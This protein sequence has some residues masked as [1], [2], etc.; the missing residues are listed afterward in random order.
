MAS[1]RRASWIAACATAVVL[2]TSGC[3][4]P[5]SVVT[6][7]EPASPPPPA[8]AAAPPRSS[9]TAPRPT[10]RPPTTAAST[11]LPLPTGPDPVHADPNRP[12]QAYDQILA[13]ILNDIQ[14]YWGTTFPHLYNKPYQPLQGGIFAVFRGAQ[15]VPGCGTRQTTYRLIQGNAFYCEQGDF[16]AFDDQTLFP[17]IYA[18]FGPYTIGMVLAHEWGHAIQ[19][20]AGVTNEPTIVLEQQADCFAGS[21]VGHLARDES[22]YL[23]V[24]ESDLDAAFAG[25]LTFSDQPGTTADQEQAHGSGFD[26][27]GAFQD[28]Y[29]NGPAKCATYPQHPPT[30]IELP[31]NQGDLG[32]GGNEPYSQIVQDLPKDLD[33]YWGKVFAARGKTFA[34]LAANLKAF[35]TGGPFPHCGGNAVPAKAVTYCEKDGM[36]YYDNDFLAGPVYDIGDFAVGLLLGN[37]WSDAAQTRLADPLAGKDRSLQGDCMTGSWTGD[38]VPKS[39]THQTFVLSAGDLDE[40]LSAFLRYGTGEPARVGTVFERTASFRKGLLQGVGACGAL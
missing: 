37:A 34:P 18:K 36:I 13:V 32:T 15:P 29:T 4:S 6:A 7:P 12:K 27:V 2:V 10:T 40:G 25:M 21:W 11:T 20:R 1:A 22:P 35:A 30:V 28:G 24:S 3:T 31:F 5:T 16:L 23:R 17:Q 38:I 19:A 39:G 8:A 14:H 26:R 33:R 9:S